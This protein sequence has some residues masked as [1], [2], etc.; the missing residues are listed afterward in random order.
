MSCHTC[1]L[2]MEYDFNKGTREQKENQDEAILMHT[3]CKDLPQ[4]ALCLIV[5][6]RS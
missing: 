1:L 3:G 4:N 5:L 6:S 2:G